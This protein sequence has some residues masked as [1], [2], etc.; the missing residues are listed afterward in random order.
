MIEI[1]SYT[2]QFLLRG[3]AHI[4][5]CQCASCRAQTP[6]VTH[7]WNNHE[8]HSALLNCDTVA[9]EALFQQ[10][11]FALTKLMTTSE[12]ETSLDPWQN[13]VNQSCI[14]LLVE[15]DMSIQTRLHAI[16]VLLSRIAR[17]EK[18]QSDL[19]LPVRLAIELLDMVAAGTLQESIQQMPALDQY[20]LAYL[21]R[22]AAVRVPLDIDA[23]A[24]MSLNLKQTELQVI[25]DS[26]LIDA[27][28]AIEQSEPVDAFFDTYSDVFRHYFLYRCF[29][30]VFPGAELAAYDLAFLDLS[31]DFFCSRSLCALLVQSG[32][33]LNPEIVAH[34][35][36]FWYRSGKASL[37]RD[38]HTDPLLIGFSLTGGGG[39]E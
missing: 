25:S 39:H 24:A 16:G 6:F 38:D 12:S 8:R 9:R 32:V 13:S 19:M 3:K 11:A 20:K 21:R 22:L 5:A 37:G 14:F 30:E 2:P 28:R 17:Q 33:E 36:A 4:A 23:Q 35:F 7:A 18:A 1:G 26:F 15:G 29:H 34:L 31:L 10:D 27:L